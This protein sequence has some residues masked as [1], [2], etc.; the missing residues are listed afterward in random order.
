MSLQLR[1]QR[2]IKAPCSIS[3]RGYWTGDANTLSFL[4]AAENAGIS[5]VIGGVETPATTE[6]SSGLALRTQLGIQPNQL[7]MIEHVMAALAGLQIDNCRV[8]CTA[9]EMPGLDGSSLA[10]T[11]ALSS[12]G[13]QEQNTSRQRLTIAEPFRVGDK[14]NWIQAEPVSHGGFEVEYQLDYAPE[15][16]IP[17][18]TYSLVV[19]PQSFSNELAPARTFVTREEANMLQA[20]GMASHVTYQD[21][22]V[23][24]EDGPVDNTLR[25]TDECSRHKALDLVGDLA[26][27]GVD[28]VGRFIARKSGHQLNAQMAIKLRKMALLQCNIEAPRDRRAA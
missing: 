7:D 12:A 26:L 16:P 21:L 5:F 10:I 20:R 2:T 22:V 8:E 15:S 14:N 24:A 28:L 3:G 25:F 18:S 23:F 4:P 11:L 9:S 13:I 1:Q 27:C 6:H 17:S 19:T